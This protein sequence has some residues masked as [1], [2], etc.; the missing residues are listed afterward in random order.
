MWVGLLHKGNTED[1]I[2]RFLISLLC[3]SK[4][5]QISNFKNHKYST[6]RMFLTLADKKKNGLY[7][8]LNLI[9]GAEN[10]ILDFEKISKSSVRKMDTL[11]GNQS[12][13][14][15]SRT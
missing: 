7:Y 10:C 3:K 15:E 4:L 11:L 12:S 8:L 13:I 2:L 6:K 5:A 9:L 14:T 1:K